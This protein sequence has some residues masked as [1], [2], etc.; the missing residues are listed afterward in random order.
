LN[1]GVATIVKLKQL[2][3]IKI[4]AHIAIEFGKSTKESKGCNRRSAGLKSTVWKSG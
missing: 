2:I 4:D 1:D 3:S